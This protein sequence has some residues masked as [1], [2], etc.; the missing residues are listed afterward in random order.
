MNKSY[1]HIEYDCECGELAQIIIPKKATEDDIEAVRE[2]KACEC[3]GKCE[4]LSIRVPSDDD[5]LYYHNLYYVECTECGKSSEDYS[6]TESG[7]IKEWNRRADNG[8]S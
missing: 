2:L 7:A 8:K 3:G 6:Q 5:C 1:N 4:V